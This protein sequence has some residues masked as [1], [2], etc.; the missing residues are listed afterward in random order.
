[1]S[2]YTLTTLKTLNLWV[3]YSVQEMQQALLDPSPLHV[4]LSTTNKRGGTG[5]AGQ[6]T[7]M[8]AHSRLFMPICDHNQIRKKRSG[9]GK[10]VHYHNVQKWQ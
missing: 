6:T 9:P 7:S 1:M 8:G 5:I 2:S 10:V 3:Y 4:N